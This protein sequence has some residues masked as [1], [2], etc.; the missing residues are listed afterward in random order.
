LV[1]AGSGLGLQNTSGTRIG[2]D[3]VIGNASVGWLGSNVTVNAK[4][5]NLVIQNQDEILSGKGPDSVFSRVDNSQVYTTGGE[6]REGSQRTVNGLTGTVNTAGSTITRTDWDGSAMFYTWNAGTGAYTRPGV[7][8]KLTFASNVWTWTDQARQVTETFDHLNGGRIMTRTDTDGNSLTYAYTSGKL[9]RVTSASGDYTDL[10]YTGNNLTQLITRKGSDNSVLASR[11]RYA[12]DG[13]NRLQTVTIDLSP[14][15]NNITDNNVVT[16]TYTY[17]S[18]STRVAS[19][20]ESGTGNIVSFVYTSMDKYRVTQVTETGSDGGTRVTNIAYDTTNKITTV[21]DALGKATAM[22]YDSNG[23]LTQIKYAPAVSGAAQQ[24]V[25]YAYNANQDVTSATDAGGKVTSYAYDSN[26]NLT[27]VRDA[28]GNTID[29]IYD[30]NN[31]LFNEIHYL[32]PDPD[33]PQ[34]GVASSPVVVRRA[35]DSENHLRFVVDADGLVSE[36]VYNA[37]GQLTSTIKYTS[38][39]YD[40]SA[41]AKTATLSESTLASWV[42]AR[43]ATDKSLVQRADAT[44]DYRGNLA[45]VVEES[46]TTTADPDDTA[47]PYT[48]TTYTYDQYGLLLSRQISGITGSQVYTYDGMGRLLS[49]TDF[50]GGTTT[51]VINDGTRTTTVTLANG[52]VK[53][54][55][56][57]AQ[58]EL[59]SYV[60]SGSDIAT[61]TETYKYDKLGRL[62]T[63]SAAAGGR[64]FTFYDDAGRKVGYMDPNGGLTEYRYDAANRLIGTIGYDNLVSTAGVSSLYDASGNPTTATIASVRPTASGYDRWNW[65]IYDTTDRLVERIDAYGNATVYTYDGD[66]RLVKTIQYATQIDDTTLAGFKTTLPTATKVPG[67]RSGGPNNPLLLRQ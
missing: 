54:S 12:Y 60:E 49:S 17:D 13:S 55:T 3:A 1:V 44:Y 26:H 30:S 33:G 6:W 28:A 45:T 5:G 9:T 62:R 66:D 14:A 11:V 38:V 22:T 18:T 19:I 23:N 10:T 2:S 46:T 43:S 40:I 61:E 8:D 21:T 15:D 34:A 25:Q 48:T 50:A 37:P 29:Y 31:Q 58:G 32:V 24:T 36:Y 4:N 51:T 7:G 41:L 57:T 39:A 35:Y 20:S 67:D 16:Y 53:T 52:L 56:Y 63:T 65:N 47:S 59:A 27:Q 42:T 64:D